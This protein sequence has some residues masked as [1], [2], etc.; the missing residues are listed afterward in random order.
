MKQRDR[1][2]VAVY[3]SALAAIDNAEA[4]PGD[5]VPAAGAIESPVVGVGRMEAA[6]RL[7]TEEDM[8]AIVR[9]EAQ[10]RRTAADV[11]ADAR[12]DAAQGL[13]REA[14]LLDALLDNGRSGVDETG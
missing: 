8:V 14:S 4:V 7:L 11:V 2:A 9:R 13:H 6:R 3:R 12:P 5:E 10:E 1:A